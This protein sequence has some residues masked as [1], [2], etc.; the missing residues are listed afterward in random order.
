MLKTAPINKIDLEAENEKLKAVGAD[1]KSDPA[2]DVK[3]FT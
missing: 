2:F 1:F 3:T